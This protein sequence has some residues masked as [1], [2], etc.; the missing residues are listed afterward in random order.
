MPHA[1][2]TC[3]YCLLLCFQ[4]NY[5][6]CL[7]PTYSL[8]K[9]NECS[10]CT[11]ETRVATRLCFCAKTIQRFCITIVGGKFTWRHTFHFLFSFAKFFD[12]RFTPKFG[13]IKVISKEDFWQ[14]NNKNSQKALPFLNIIL[15]N[16]F[17]SCC[18]EKNRWKY[19]SSLKFSCITT[20]EGH[21]LRMDKLQNK[22]KFSSEKLVQYFASKYFIWNVYL[23]G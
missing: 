13:I 4:R 7:K 12:G 16:Y 1:F 23:D 9:A 15:M 21:L 22:F 8:R 14:C 11:L 3:V 10:K 20:W 19:S 18:L 6:G 5:Y 2:S 17:L